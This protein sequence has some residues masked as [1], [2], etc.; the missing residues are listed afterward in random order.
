MRKEWKTLT[1]KTLTIGRLIYFKKE[2]KFE[3]IFHKVS[4]NL[5]G[6]LVAFDEKLKL[7]FINDTYIV[8]DLGQTCF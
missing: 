2:K 4:T 3:S 6:V 7:S 1:L 8:T 5:Y